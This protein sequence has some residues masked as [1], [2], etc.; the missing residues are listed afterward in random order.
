MNEAHGESSAFCEVPRVKAD[1]REDLCYLLF[2]RNGSPEI[3]SLPFNNK[4]PHSSLNDANSEC[5][6]LRPP[7][8]L[9]A[10]PMGEKWV[11][12]LTERQMRGIYLREEDFAR[13]RAS[14]SVAETVEYFADRG[15]DLRA[16]WLDFVIV[17]TD[18]IPGL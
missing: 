4:D 8:R 16:L 2:H 15:L 7:P 10:T 11:L 17:V 13:A 1:K 18:G 12:V 5:R 9:F 6:L 14:D 3:S